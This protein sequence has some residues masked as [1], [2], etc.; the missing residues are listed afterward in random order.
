MTSPKGLTYIT[1]R[2]EFHAAHPLRKD[3][4]KDLINKSSIRENAHW[5]GHHFELFITVKGVPDPITGFVI[6][7]KELKLLIQTLVI[8]QLDHKNLQENVSFLKGLVPSI[9]NLAIQIWEILKTALS[10]CEM[11]CVRI[12]ETQNNFVEYFG[13]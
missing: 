11:H 5:H 9:E 13:E 7:L 6:D 3:H 2:M 4:A 12:V 8:D 10:N 1:R